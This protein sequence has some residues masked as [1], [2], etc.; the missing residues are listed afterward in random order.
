MIN[1]LF[2]S[3][4]IPVLEQVVNF[5]GARH[6]LL[7]GNIANMDTPGYQIRDL[8]VETFQQRLRDAIET[9]NEQREPV[10]PGIITNEAK[11]SLHEVADSMRSVLYHDGSDVGMEQQVTEMI[12]NQ[13][14]YNMAIAVMTSQFRLLQVAIS[15]RV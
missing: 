2:N 6:E 3:T 11:D 1:S 15:E 7:A 5:S 12:K 13:S 8:S 4:S 14:T 9:R 10:S